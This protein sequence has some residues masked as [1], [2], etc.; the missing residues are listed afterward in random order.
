[1]LQLIWQ[2]YYTLNPV[3][4]AHWMHHFSEITEVKQLNPISD[5]IWEILMRWV[6]TL[7]API[8]IWWPMVA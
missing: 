2:I 5:G 3:D 1:M 6:C 7:G 4:I 8:T